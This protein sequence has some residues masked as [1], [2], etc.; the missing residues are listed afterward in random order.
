MSV[1]TSALL[2]LA[3]KQSWREAKIF[4][5]LFLALFIAVASSSTVNYFAERLH[6]AMSHKASEFL[7]A[8]VAVSGTA[9]A[10]EEQQRL[11]QQLSLSGTHTVEFSTML[12]SNEEMVLASIKAITAEYPLKGNLRS[13]AH[14]EA[15]DT[16]G[17]SPASGEIWLEAALFHSLNIEPGDK[18]QVGATTLVASRV[19]TYEPSQ[20]SG[21]IS[22]F[23]PLAL[24]N[25]IDLAAT[26]AVQA[27][28]RIFYRYLWVGEEA[29]ITTFKQEVASLLLPQQQIR[30]LEDTSPPLF[31]ALNRAQQYLNLTSLVAILLAS[32]GIALS[33]THFAKRRT[34]QAAL[35]RCFGL[36][37]RQTLSFFIVQLLLAGCLASA[38]GV[39]TG[40]MAQQLLFNL[41]ADLLPTAI[42][43][44]KLSTGLIT[45]ST[46]LVM[47]FCFALPPLLTLGRVS[48]M[49]VLREDLA[50]I[51]TQAWLI[52]GLA[53]CGLGFVM[54]QLS[55]NIW[56]T[57]LLLL[58]GLG[59]ALLLGGALYWIF[60]VL[61]RRL[62]A[63]LSWRLGLG[64][65]LQTPL[66]AIS[67][68]LA[69]TLIMLAMALVVLLRSELLNNWQQQLPEDAPN[70]FA[71]NIMP[72]EQA[73]FAHTL[74]T[75]STNISP[76]YPMTP[77]R[78][79]HI[80]QTPILEHLPKGSPAERTIQRDLNLTWAHELPAGNQIIRGEWWPRNSAVV[81]ISVEDKLAERLN[82]TLGDEV[83]FNLGGRIIHSQ[84]ANLRRVDW[85]LIQPNFFIIFAPNYLENLPHTWLTSFHLAPEHSKQLRDIHQTFPAVSFLNVGAV[86]KQLKEIMTQVSLA[87]ESLLIFVLAAGIMV[88]L[89]GI[90]STLPNRI[91]QSAL[92][93]A[94][95]AS[96]TFIRRLHFF[97]FATIGASSGILAWIG[98]ELTS[99]ILYTWVF[100]L[101][102]QPHPWLAMLPLIG[103]LLI[104]SVG[105][106]GTRQVAN[107]SPMQ[108]L[109]HIN[110]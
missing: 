65:L 89:A 49:R 102:W 100:E 54:W 24:M 105:L 98:A 88:L 66:L 48:P 17:G 72:H 87:I 86:L 69:F 14:L 23:Q 21:G 50:P 41:L 85:S 7:G 32:V 73:R 45:G 61:S 13:Q 101:P 9:Q 56:L 3:I 38:L 43:P 71:F 95:G 62:A 12:A 8:D 64:H 58:G 93:R 30:T 83:T 59:T 31:Q 63:R 25:Q 36:S 60:T 55:L 34:Q 94:L 107:A 75:I 79:T 10:T 28:S 11:A 4:T 5:V 53:L 77:G 33:A 90:Q 20:A 37:R 22:T 108:T 40:W 76:Y 15:E 1:A 26:Q 99:V 92:L 52:Y 110:S 57:M 19:L 78:L 47:L 27:G 104:Y 44:A 103:A 81:P 6:L 70:H 109:R 96:R 46:G 68:I 82:L 35:L 16:A 51:P 29:A 67:Q 2:G 18:L 97:E 74:T 91:H 106:L 42:P 80:N 84:V 39:L